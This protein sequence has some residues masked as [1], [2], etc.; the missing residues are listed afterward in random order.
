MAP[1]VQATVSGLDDPE[2]GLGVRLDRAYRELKALF[3]ESG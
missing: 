1:F 3:A 2:T